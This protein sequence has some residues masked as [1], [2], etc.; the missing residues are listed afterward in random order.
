MKAMQ[1]NMERLMKVVENSKATLAANSAG[2]LSGVK[3]VPISDGV[4]VSEC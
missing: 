4:V 1:A 3:S 2:K